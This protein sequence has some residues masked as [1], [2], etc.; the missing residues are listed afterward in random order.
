[1]SRHNHGRG[2]RGGVLLCSLICSECGHLNTVVRRKQ[3]PQSH[4]HPK[5]L[6][7]PYCKAETMHIQ[8]S[9]HRGVTP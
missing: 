3:R 4:G 7:C 8:I 9:D 1:M 2:L 6:W 5:H